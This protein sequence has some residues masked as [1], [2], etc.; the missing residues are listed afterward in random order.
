MSR[1]RFQSCSVLL[2]QLA[3]I[4][5]SSMGMQKIL[6]KRLQDRIAD[7]QHDIESIEIQII[8]QSKPSMSP[9]NIKGMRGLQEMYQRRI[10]KLDAKIA[11]VL[12]QV[13][14]NQVAHMETADLLKPTL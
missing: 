5:R 1:R 7:A 9:E 6:V 11:S 13:R 4:L 2:I 8:K 3:F 12:I 10:V 14:A